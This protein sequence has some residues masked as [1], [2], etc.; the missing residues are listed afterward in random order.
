MKCLTCSNDTTKYG[1]PYALGYCSESC[2]YND[3]CPSE[4]SV[5]KRLHENTSGDIT[6]VD[7]HLEQKVR[8]FLKMKVW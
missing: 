7:H 5:V 6:K 1:A 8:E 2:W 3:G 4:T